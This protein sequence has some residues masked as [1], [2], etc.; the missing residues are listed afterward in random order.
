[1][2]L[3]LKIH[4]PEAEPYRVDYEGD[5][6]DAIRYEAEIIAADAGSDEID[7]PSAEARQA[8]AEEIIAAATAAL[9]NPGDT[10]RDPSK[11]HGPL[12][13]LWSLELDNEEDLDP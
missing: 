13:V 6:E 4:M 7:D 9:R 5:L 2:S 1:M 8:Y 12:G 3:W 11:V 10:Y